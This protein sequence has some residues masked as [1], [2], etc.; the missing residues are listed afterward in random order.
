MGNLCQLIT[1][2]HHFNGVAKQ[3]YSAPTQPVKLVK[4]SAWEEGQEIR[5][6]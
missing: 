3:A 2:I 4:A 6:L 5:H 1:A